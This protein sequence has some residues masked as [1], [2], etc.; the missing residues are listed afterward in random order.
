LEN[1]LEEPTIRDHHLAV[2]EDSEREILEWIKVQIEK[3]KSIICTDLRH[4]YKAKYFHS[5]NRRWVDSFILHHRDNLIE[6]K[7]ALQEDPTLE[8]PHTFMD[9]TIGCLR[10]YVQGIKVELVFNLDEIGILE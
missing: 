9:K 6:I 10:E 5:V 1:G 8:M 3:C 7:S 4:Y 2:D